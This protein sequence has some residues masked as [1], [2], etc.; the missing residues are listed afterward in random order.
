MVFVTFENEKN[1]PLNEVLLSFDE[2]GVKRKLPALH[3]KWKESRCFTRYAAFP[4]RNGLVDEGSS[5]EQWVSETEWF[6]KDLEW[7]LGLEHFRFWSTVVHNPEAIEAVISFTQNAIPY[8]LIGMV[9]SSDK[10]FPLYSA[11]HRCTL[12]VVCRMITQKESDRCWIGREVLGELLYKHYLVS[13]PLI[14]DLLPIYGRDNKAVLGLMLQTIFKLQPKYLQ[15]LR[16]GL[17]Y[18]QNTF[19]TIQQR[20]DTDLIEGNQATSSTLNDLAVYT[21]DCCSCL[22][23]LVD[24]YPDVRPICTDLALEQSISNF[25]DNTIVLLYKNIFAMDNASP[26]LV[27]LNA[28]RIELLSAFRGILNLQLEMILEKPEASLAPADKFLCVLTEC[29]SDPIFVRD[30][31]RHYPVDQ[32]LD[33]LKQSYQGLDHIKLEFVQNAY[34]SGENGLTN[35]HDRCEFPEEDESFGE[36]AGGVAEEDELVPSGTS[37]QKELTPEQ[38]IETNVQKVLDILPD[39]GDGYVRKILTRYDDVEQAIAAVLEGNLP[40]DLAEADPTEPYI[41]PDKLDN[42]YVETGIDRLNIY[43]GDEFDVLVHDQIKGVMKKGKGMPGQPKNLKEMLDDKSH[44]QE[45]KERYQEYSNVCDEYDDEYDDSYDAMADSESK[46]IRLSAQMRNAL[47]DELDDEEDEE[48]DDA[49]DQAGTA[50]GGGKKPLD[51]CVNPEEL[52]QRA[53]ERRRS[54]Y[55]ARGGGGPPGGGQNRDVVGKA[56]GQGQ[57]KEVLANRKH[58]NENKSS[59]A[60]HNRKQGATFKRNKGMIPS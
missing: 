52:R 34:S 36:A 10:V 29:L 9:R 21:L 8:Y 38:Q 44:V 59:R 7:L 30:Y 26:Y 18:L 27:Q 32:D 39:L 46:T 43:D 50:P 22:A 53:E 4:M 40:P 31:Q 55:Q 14:F 6:V 17:Q 24:L 57:E 16:V 49:E 37:A 25:Y 19:K 48:E 20:I 5:L 13:I 42:F 1:L 45:M 47:V 15:D 60:N 3:E 58:K 28:A 41:P 23:L 35:G 56:K 54:K 12:Q 11:A 2:D 51:F 33:I